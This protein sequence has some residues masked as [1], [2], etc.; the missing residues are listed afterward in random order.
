[1][2][3]ERDGTF[4]VAGMNHTGK[5]YRQIISLDK[6]L[7]KGK[8]YMFEMWYDS[9]EGLR[10]ETRFLSWY[11]KIVID[12][13]NDRGYAFRVGNLLPSYFGGEITSDVTIKNFDVEKVFYTLDDTDPS[14][15][16]TAILYDG[17]PIKMDKS[18]YLRAVAFDGQQKV[19]AFRYRFNKIED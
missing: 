7:T 16:S 19:S 3:K 13:P 18:C 1:M 9:P 11:D 8:R 6:F 12:I 2:V 4:F 17:E 14:I 10:G 15:S 5:T